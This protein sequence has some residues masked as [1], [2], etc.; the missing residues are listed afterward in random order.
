MLQILDSP[1]ICLMTLKDKFICEKAFSYRTSVFFL[2]TFM[3]LSSCATIMNK[4]N[5]HLAILTGV[6]VK[7]VFGNDTIS[8]RKITSSRNRTEFVVPRQKDS[9][10]LTLL[11]DSLKKNIVLHSGNSFAYWLNV[12]S[13]AG[14]GVLVDKSS[15]KRYT[16]P[17]QFSVDIKNAKT[18]SMIYLPKGFKEGMSRNAIKFTPLRLLFSHPGIELSYERYLGN[19]YSL[20][21]G[22][23]HLYNITFE[24]P[25]GNGYQLSLEGKYFDIPRIKGI[26]PYASIEAGY[27][28][29]RIEDTWQG[30]D[31]SGVTSSFNGNKTFLYVIPKIGAQ[32]SFDNKFIIDFYIGLGVKHEH[33]VYYNEYSPYEAFID[34]FW[35]MKPSLNLK[36]GFRF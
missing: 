32:N 33:G 23:A 17:K 9:I 10:K 29:I 16:F 28:N 12:V 1:K 7:V 19:C 30:Y 13:T 18:D 27:F 3:L 8:S 34:D 15:N 25:S 4:R 5:V 24:Y 21:V 31:S 2:L 35:Q 14:V 20:Q 36:L 11:T 6:P 26:V 22:A